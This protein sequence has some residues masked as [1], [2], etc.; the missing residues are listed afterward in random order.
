M[1]GAGSARHG[2]RSGTVSPLAA[3]ESDARPQR[4]RRRPQRWE[5]VST[6]RAQVRRGSVVAGAHAGVLAQLPPLRRTAA[7][8]AHATGVAATAASVADDDAETASIRSTDSVSPPPEAEC[9]LD[10]LP[11][12]LREAARNNPVD[13]RAMVDEFHKWQ[14]RTVSSESNHQKALH[15]YLKRRLRKRVVKTA[16]HERIEEDALRNACSAAPSDDPLG[17]GDSCDDDDEETRAAKK[18]RRLE[19]AIVPDKIRLPLDAYL[20]RRVSKADRCITVDDLL[21]DMP[22]LHGEVKFA[23]WTADSGGAGLGGGADGVDDAEYGE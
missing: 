4:S 20:P 23:E 18:Q 5:G 9:P 13:R 16:E 7:A 22:I 1:T 21:D 11:D 19:A 6:G 12:A 15:A 10:K 14:L 17:E 8:D 3:N 2:S